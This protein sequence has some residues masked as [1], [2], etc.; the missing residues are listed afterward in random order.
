[1][2]SVKDSVS[3]FLLEALDIR[4]AVVRLEQSWARL[5]H[6]R[7]Y[8]AAARTLL[9]EVAAVSTLIGA[10]LKQPGRL[11]FQ[12]QGDGPIPLLVM[13]LDSQLRLRGMAKVD[14]PL[15]TGADLPAMLGDGKLVLTLQTEH[16]P[17]PY[18][19]LVPLAGASVAEVF[20]SF[21]VQSE[22]Q[23]AGLWLAADEHNA[24]G[25]FL[26]RMPGADARDADG[27]NRVL[28]L[29]A[30]VK[31]QELLRLPP[32]EL[33]TRLFHEEDLRLY[34][35]RPVSYH[36]PQDWEKVRRIVRS[37]GRDQALSLAYEHGE[38][39][40]QD[41]ICNFEYRFTP[42]EVEALFEDSTSRRTLH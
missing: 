3:R 21:L 36:C 37:I 13:E 6:G 23:P 17:Q 39:T 22:Q 30:T 12:I 25:L 16:S 4:G 29:A 19:S 24:A 15:P 1:M 42:Q 2:S 41:D 14:A 7:H 33:L 32:A 31:Q 28:Q 5:Q 10:N 40:L 18:Q 27:W 34:D 20:Q 11:T 8:P 9:G 35:P 38:L 26:Q